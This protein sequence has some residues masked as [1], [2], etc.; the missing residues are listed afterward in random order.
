MCLCSVRRHIKTSFSAAPLSPCAFKG[1]P[2]NIHLH[3]KRRLYHNRPGI[4]AME[5]LASIS[6]TSAVYK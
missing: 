1:P 3:E 5:I 2:Q 4:P 6:K